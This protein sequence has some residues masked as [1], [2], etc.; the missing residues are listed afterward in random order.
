VAVDLAEEPAEGGDFEA[1]DG[2]L[3]G[4]GDDEQALADGRRR[5]RRGG[6]RRTR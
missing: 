5:G 1:V 2:E 3:A 6:R 4:A